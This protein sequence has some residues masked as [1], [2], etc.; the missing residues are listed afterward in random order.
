[1]WAG[2]ACWLMPGG[3]LPVRGSLSRGVPDGGDHEVQVAVVQAG[4]VSRRLAG[5]PAAMLAASWRMRRSPPQTGSCPVCRALVAASQ[6]IVAMA[7]DAVGDA[8]AGVHEAGEVAS[9]Q[10]PAVADE[11]R[12]TGTL[13]VSSLSGAQSA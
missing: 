5:V 7:G 1:M 6:S 10:E 13:A 12:W 11:Q 8:G 3:W 2:G 9:V 4:M